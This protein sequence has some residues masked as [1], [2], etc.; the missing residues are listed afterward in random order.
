MA[1]FLSADHKKKLLW[2]SKKAEVEQVLCQPQ[3][4]QGRYGTIHIMIFN[5]LEGVEW[6][7]ITCVVL[8]A[9]P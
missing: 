6:V 5:A 4:I 2:G 7:A 1:G 9:L 8:T 3:Q